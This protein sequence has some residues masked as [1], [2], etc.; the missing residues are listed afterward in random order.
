MT[1]RVIAAE[2]WDR[3]RKNVRWLTWCQVGGS[4]IKQAEG[5]RHEI[6]SERQSHESFFIG[7]KTG[8]KKVL[9]PLVGLEETEVKKKNKARSFLNKFRCNMIKVGKRN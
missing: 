8:L 5:V 9:L 2:G 1:G 7:V 4:F 6:L 3:A